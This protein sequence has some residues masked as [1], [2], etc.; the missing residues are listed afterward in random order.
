MDPVAGE[1]LAELIAT[2]ITSA[3][4]RAWHS[5]KPSPEGRAL[6]SAIVEALSSAMRD[7]ALPMGQAVNDAWMADVAHVWE[8]A[9]TP[10]VSRHLVAC[11]A[12]SSADSA[13]FAQL[14]TR[15]LVDGG[16]DLAEL[17]RTLQVEEFL[18]V[19]PRRLLGCLR[20]AALRDSA[21][22][23]LVAILLLFRA[24][25]QG[26]G[27]EPPTPGEFRQD[28]ISMLRRL[29]ERACTG[30]LPPYLRPGANVTVLS[31]TVKVQLNMRPGP[32]TRS[33]G[34]VPQQ[35][36]V[37]LYD[38][39]VERTAGSEPPQPWPQ[40]VAKY[41][42]LVVLADPGLGKSWLIRTETHR[43]C[44]DALARLANGAHAVVI[45]VPMRCDQLATAAGQDLAEKAASH[46]V[47]Q[48]LLAGRSSAVVAA[49]IRSGKT[50]VLLDALDELTAAERGPLRELVR[51]WAD[52][53]GDDAQCV[54]TSR[55]A[56]YTGSPLPKAREVELQAFTR[57]DVAAA[58]TAWRLPPVAANRLQS[59]LGDP[60][61]AAMARIPLLL[62]LLCS[63]AAEVPA[64]KALPRTR[65]QLYERMLRWFLTKAHRSQDDPDMLLLDN[66]QV[67]ALLEILAPIAYTFA[68]QAGGWTDLMPVESLLSAIRTSG[69]P[70]SE[71]HRPAGE[72]LRELSVGVG[73]LVP[74]GDPSA[75]RNPYYLFLHRTVAEYL[76]AR[77]LANL[78]EVEWLAVVD[79]HRW[80]DPYWAEVIPMLGEQLSLQAARKLIQHLLADECDPFYHSLLMA[81]RI[82][83]TRVD[84]NHLL[85]DGQAAELAGRLSSFLRNKQTRSSISALFK[86]MTYMP[87][88]LI[89]QLLASLDAQD[90]YMR[91]TAAEVLAGR[92]EP[93]VTQALIASLADQHPSV[94]FAAVRALAE[95]EGQEVTKALTARLA[96]EN[97]D[98]RSAAAEALAVREGPGVMDA[99]IGCLDDR[100]E[101]V[102]SAVAG[103]LT[104]RQEPEVL[105]ALIARLTDKSPAVRTATVR[106]LAAREQPAVT[107]ALIARLRDGVHDVQIAVVEELAEREHLGVTEA[108]V[109]FLNHEEPE[110][111]TAVSKALAVR[112]TP[113]VSKALL[114]CLTK[115]GWFAQVAAAEV[116][117]GRDDPGLTHAL[118]AL[119]QDQDRLVR[120]AAAL[121]LGEGQYP[122]VE[123]VLTAWLTDEDPDMRFW[124]AESL[125]ARND[126]WV[127]EALLGGLRDW[128]PEARLAAAK[129]LT[130][131]EH[132][133]LAEALIACL[134][135]QD[136]DVRIAAAN[137][138]A[139]LDDPRVTE[140]LLDYLADTQADARSA[141]LTARPAVIKALASRKSP[142]AIRTLLNCLADEDAS[143]R[144]AAVCALAGR[145]ESGVTQALVGCIA[146]RDENVRHA[147]VV[148]LATRE[149]AEVTEAL[150]GCLNDRDVDVRL[151]AADALA[152]RKDSEVTQGLLERLTGEDPTAWKAALEALAG[153]DSA[154]SLLGLAKRVRVLKQASVGHAIGAAEEL[155]V[156]HYRRIDPVDQVWVR[157]EMGWLTTA[158]SAD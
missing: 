126:P 71:L 77:H 30:Q 128:N 75:G 140:A 10:D 117:A 81:A 154:E 34:E 87:R 102:R 92:G 29:D 59:R 130:G 51:S 110:V 66:V 120:Y 26:S 150:L 103:S 151:T 89:V 115:Q 37:N 153:R 133:E 13:R 20:E 61:I 28:L 125:S 146:D 112:A 88:L 95:Q 135:D 104:R 2:A 46:L 18:A 98:L 45:P 131:R 58:V 8:R 5:A 156:R 127:T 96:D 22:R 57:E 148:A 52:N 47:T 23:Q 15:A 94:R 91:F 97:E 85:P 7:S 144:Y 124:A 106:A 134:A 1:V 74:D 56:G 36:T 62:A 53:A 147:A 82:W 24:D 50:I 137:G 90:W 9:F 145:D 63:L 55:I 119:L 122:G 101:D 43:L 38:L 41:K 93:E 76:T 155:M 80:F 121:A 73:I 100:D 86:G 17:G 84:A 35:S 64:G 70:F 157:A 79:Q 129:A 149:G 114:D 83:G 6:K 108:L 132:P 68:A 142:E 39:P 60:A 111:Q 69:P 19:L 116:L 21:L 107:D 143:V 139:Q 78:P 123:E 44:E 4:G 27:I 67:E 14:A 109:N 72:I 33:V 48:G 54:I 12:G 42:R 141:S 152:R 99:L 11:I 31:R 25:G 118:L 105:A 138:L 32:L 113:E 65:S 16:C 3:T 40:V 136:A 49:R 158:L